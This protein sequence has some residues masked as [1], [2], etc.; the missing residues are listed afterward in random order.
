MFAA[1][2]FV[3][4]IGDWRIRCE[5]THSLKKKEDK[6]ARKGRRERQYALA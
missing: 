4:A 6:E 1:S 3:F 5:V 2:A